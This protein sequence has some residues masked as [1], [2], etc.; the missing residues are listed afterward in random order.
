MSFQDAVVPSY[1]Y[2]TI[3]FKAKAPT[4][5]DASVGALAF[6]SAIIRLFLRL[7]S[8]FSKKVHFFEKGLII[9]MLRAY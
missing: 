6:M 5:N 7:S 9:P 1:C 4:E 3:R 2:A 8:V